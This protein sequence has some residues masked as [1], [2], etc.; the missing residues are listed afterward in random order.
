MMKI[1]SF[2]IAWA[3]TYIQTQILTM[4]LADTLFRWYILARIVS[5]S[6]MELVT[7]IMRLGFLLRRIHLAQISSIRK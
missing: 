7:N 1:L 2:H 4:M 6:R 3:K 5:S